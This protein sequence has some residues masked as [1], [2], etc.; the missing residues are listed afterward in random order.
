MGGRA[1]IRG[2]RM[3]VS[4]VVRMVASGMSPAE[5]I[6]AGTP[7][8]A[9]S[10]RDPRSRATALALHSGIARRWPRPRASHRHAQNPVS[11][12]ADAKGS[13]GAAS[14]DER[15]TDAATSGSSH[16]NVSRGLAVSIPSTK[17]K[18]DG[19]NTSLLTYSDV[20]E[21]LGASGVP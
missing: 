15:C 14:S 12:A 4:T 20:P 9:P 2:L 13:V 3:P 11:L 7:T 1:C 6:D 16:N 17:Q 10:T 8:S 21:F 19:H 18:R 5:I